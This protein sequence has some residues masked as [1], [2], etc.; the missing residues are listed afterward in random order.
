MG[1]YNANWQL[2]CPGIWQQITARVTGPAVLQPALWKFFV[3]VLW[4]RN[5]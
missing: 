5:C 3:P 1:C 2:K 4:H